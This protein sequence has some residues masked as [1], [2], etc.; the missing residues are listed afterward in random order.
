M[1]DIIITKNGIYNNLCITVDNYKV[2]FVS[3]NNSFIKNVTSKL[4]K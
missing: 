3:V 2:Q 1:E 4:I